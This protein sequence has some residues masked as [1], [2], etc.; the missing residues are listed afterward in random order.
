M[1]LEAVGSS[2]TTHPTISQIGDE[3]V[4]VSPSGKALDFDSSI[5]KFKSCHPCQI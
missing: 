5:R 3:N 2:P 4:G 1:A